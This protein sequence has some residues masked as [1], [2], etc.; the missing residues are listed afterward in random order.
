MH[1]LVFALALISACAPATRSLQLDTT[2]QKIAGHGVD[3]A[4]R[5][6]RPAGDVRGVVVIHHGLA[7]HGA[8]Y[9][10]LAEQLTRAGYVVWAH[11]MRGH[12]RSAGRRVTVDHIDD[13]LEDLDA[14]VAQARAT[15][16]DRPLFVMGHSLGGLVTALYAIERQP[17]VAGVVLS[18]PGIAFDVP[19]FAVGGIRFIS[20]IAPNAPILYNPHADFSSSKEVVAD[21][22][23]DPLI[24]NPRGP[25]RTSRAA[26]DG[27][28]RIWAHPERLVAP[29]LALHGTA[30]KI[31]APIASRDIVARAGTTDRTL[32]LYDGFAHDLLH[33]PGAAQVSAD[34]IA[35]LDA[36]AAGQRSSLPSA[37]P[38]PLAGDR[39]ASALGIELDARGERTDDHQGITGGLRVR[40]GIGRIGY[41]AGLDLRGGYLGGAWLAGDLHALGVGVRAANGTSFAL[42]GGIGVLRTNGATTTHLPIEAALELPLGPVHLMARAGVAYRLSGPDS[43]EDAL[44]L[45][46]EARGLLGIRLG[47]D[48]HYWARTTAGAGPFL[49]VTYQNFGGLDVIGLALGGQLWG[50]S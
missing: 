23:K 27:V 32:R 1:R 11:D 2:T 12:A 40:A 41:A 30:D 48:A 14:V 17:N 29:L 31:V 7:D 5:S 34:L 42:T 18:A 35:W 20:A 24:E 21:M 26:T 47:R 8:R 46:D 10:A 44:G 37:R 19:A 49:A 33:E 36:H 16:P 43:A 50:G 4:I 9:A 25:A 13:L 38:R 39:G 15:D 45:A 6:W 28:R 3:L 22:A